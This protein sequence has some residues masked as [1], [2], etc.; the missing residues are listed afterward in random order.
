M[1]QQSRQTCKTKDAEFSSGDT[2]RGFLA[3]AVTLIAG[4]LGVLVPLAA[5]LAAFLSPIRRKSAGG[6]FYKLATLDMLPEDG[7]PRR[8]S[9]VAARADAWNVY[10]S[11]PIGAVFLRRVG[12]GAVAFQVVCPH[13]GCSITYQPSAQGGRFF[14]PCHLA[15]FDL[16]G[17]RLDSTSP[18]PRDMDAL[19][20]E[21]RDGGEIWVRFQNFAL[22][23][24]GKAALG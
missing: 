1:E 12:K 20:T 7:S 19:D 15:G 4:A 10:P 24:A 8:F 6:A 21:I 23:V 16:D 9:V 14:C 13:A 11:Q 18:S 17:T 2:R 3:W 22:G 5:G